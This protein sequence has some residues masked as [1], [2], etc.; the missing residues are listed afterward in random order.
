[1]YLIQTEELVFTHFVVATFDRVI[2]ACARIGERIENFLIDIDGK[3]VK[4]QVNSH[5]EALPTET[6]WDICREAEANYGK[7]PLYRT[8]RLEV[9]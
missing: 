7:V 9:N 5:F 8:K 2:F 1:M 6:A 3:W 4:Q